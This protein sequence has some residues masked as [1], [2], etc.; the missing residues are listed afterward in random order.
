M[1]R[2]GKVEG[3]DDPEFQAPEEEEILAGFDTD[4]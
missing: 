1:D 4:L 2:D 3:M